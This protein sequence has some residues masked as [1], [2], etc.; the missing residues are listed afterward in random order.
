MKSLFFIICSVFLSCASV[1][2]L[3]GGEKDII[4][5]K[6]IKTSVDSGSLN[7]TTN[8]F[9]FTFSENVSSTNTN[10]LLL[11]SPT[12]R[13]QPTLEINGN[14]GTLTLRDTL[15]PN[16]TYTIQF[17]GC[18]QDINEN[19]PML[20][21]TYI[22]S[23]GSYLDSSSFSGY[24]KDMTTN[25]PCKNC[26]VQ[27]YTSKNDSVVV[28]RKPDYI[29][30]TDE[31]GLYHFTNLP[32]Q[33]FKLIALRDANKNLLLD[34]DEFISLAQD[35]DSSLIPKDTTHIFPFRHYTDYTPI[36]LKPKEAGLVKIAL[37]KPINHSINIF[38]NDSLTSYR[39]N[40]SKDTIMAYYPPT[41]DTLSV[42]LYIDT[43]SFSFV[44]T[45]T[46]DNKKNTLDL[47]FSEE[48]NLVKI[49][50]NTRINNINSNL[51]KLYN[52]STLIPITGSYF[53]EYDI[54]L[55]HSSSL[56][57]NRLKMEEYA[58]IDILL[59]NN[60]TSQN[61]IPPFKNYRSN[62]N[63]S[64]TIDSNS[65]IL[66]IYKDKTIYKT[67]YIKSS[68]ELTFN[69][70][71]PGNYSCQLIRDTNKNEIWDSGDYFSKISPEQI[72]FTSPFEMRE[73]WD[74]DLI[75]NSL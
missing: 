37:Q 75:I 12:Q 20:D 10:E 54:Y 25:L 7:I 17:N 16:T 52:D 67:E 9:R 39:L 43:V 65:Y 71:P 44:H 51:I 2:T 66:T 53:N 29:A 60:I 28:K 64:I 62:L 6:V 56:I 30:K 4:P 61:K 22:F 26:N 11:V 24:V 21:Y 41:V 27:L 57:P 58:I 5:P 47:T 40:R 32:K 15:I 69:N 48:T 49:H 8:S 70:L 35:L 50:S 23:T 45:Y 73:N 42:L 55:S 14:Q 1:Q 36:L 31:I 3:T 18:I 46:T 72:L 33:P 74:K 63:L 19:N 34:N 59:N 68:R 38:L 13:N